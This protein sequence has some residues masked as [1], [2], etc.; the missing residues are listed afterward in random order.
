MFE[1][2]ERSRSRR[3]TIAFLV[4]LVLA[5]GALF[6]PAPQADAMARAIRTTVLVPLIWLQTRAE[7]GKASRS[8]LAA[9]QAQRDSLARMAQLVP[10]LRDENGGLRALLGLSQRLPTRFVPAEILHQSQPTDGRTLLLNVGTADGVQPFQPVVAPEGLLGV[11]SS[12]E[13]HSSIALTWAHPEFRASAY[14]EGDGVFGIVASSTPG[15]S[16]EPLLELRG[17]P[18]RDSVPPG[19]LVLSSGLGG[20]YPHGIPLGRVI[21]VARELTGWERVYLVR[22]AANPGQAAHALV[23][24]DGGD[25]AVDSAYP[26]SGGP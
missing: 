21:G 16:D 9:I 8:R 24:L 4:C 6:A 2:P 10:E 1:Y 23:L 19:T 3:D 5:C 15:A 12:A 17:V 25:R 20:V 22:P 14:T 26:A 7:E 11:I 13:S 18:Y